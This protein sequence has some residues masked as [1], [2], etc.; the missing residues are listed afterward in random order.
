MAVCDLS[1]KHINNPA[2]FFLSFIVTH[3]IQPVLNVS[4]GEC[5]SERRQGQRQHGAEM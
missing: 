3:S 1:G 5:A 2:F 4:T